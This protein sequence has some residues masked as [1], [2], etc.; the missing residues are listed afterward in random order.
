MIWADIIVENLIP[1][2]QLGEAFQ[3]LLNIPIDKIKVIDDYEDF[4]DANTM[5]VVCQKSLFKD[6]FVMM[7]SIY[8][9]GEIAKNIPRLDVFVSDFS[10]VTNCK[11][12]LPSEN[13]NPNQMMLYDGSKREVAF[14]D[15]KIFESDEI[16]LLK[17]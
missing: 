8:L 2:E 10:K 3:K 17:K 7:L 14:I 5:S 13:D 15:G 9:F 1:N 12:L 11:C 4:P 16:Y 6:G